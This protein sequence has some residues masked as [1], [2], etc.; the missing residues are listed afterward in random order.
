MSAGKL[1][2]LGLVTM[3][4]VG[5]GAPAPEPEPEPCRRGGAGAAAVRG[6]PASTPAT[7]VGGRAVH[8]RHGEPRGHR[9]RPRRG[10]GHRLRRPGGRPAQRRE[11]RRQDRDPWCSP[12]P[13][14]E[15]RLDADAYPECPGPFDLR[16]PGHIPAPRA[17]T[18]SRGR[19]ASTLLLVVHHGPREAIGVLRGECR[20]LAAEP[21]LGGLRGSAGGRQPQ[22]GGRPCLT[23]GSPLTNAGIGVW[24]WQA[25]S[26]WEVLPES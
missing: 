21:G 14:S 15:Q 7:R 12:P 4:A 25:D 1:A 16:Q 10:V 3:I 8:L 22:L 19:G 26:G 24:E 9:G 6:S 2:G 23:A 17:S 11:R 18:S 5:C 20:R 13:D